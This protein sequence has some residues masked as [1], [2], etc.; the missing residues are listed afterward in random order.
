M[1]A[2]S[3]FWNTILPAVSVMVTR[4][5]SRPSTLMATKLTMPWICLGSSFAPLLSVS[6][7]EALGLRCSSMNRLLAG[8]TRCTRAFSTW[9]NSEMVRDSSPCRARW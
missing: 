9:G 2:P 4:L 3:L 1:L 8:S 6:T 7:T 5:G